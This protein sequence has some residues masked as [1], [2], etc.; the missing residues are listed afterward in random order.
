MRNVTVILPTYNESMSLERMT[1]EILTH[2]PHAAIL[3]VDDNSPDGTGALAEKLAKNEPRITLLSRKGKEG[4][5]KAYLHAFDVILADPT[6]NVVCMMDCDFSHDPATLPVLIA[7]C[8]QHDVAIGSRYVRGGEMVGWSSWRRFLSMGG[9]LYAQLV[10]RMPVRDLTAGFYALRASVL[11]AL[12]RERIDSSGYAFQ[13][14]LKCALH[15][16]GARFTEVPITFRERAGGESKLS[17][18]IISEGVVA[19]WKIVWRR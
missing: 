16:S 4:L 8:E 15:R 11:R 6:V 5:G 1:R 14:E 18:H 3:V 12:S 13:I 9:N 17:G 19:P 10:T 2:V 7:A